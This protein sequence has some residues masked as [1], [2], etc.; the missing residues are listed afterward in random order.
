MAQA[1]FFLFYPPFLA[2]AF[3]NLA[4]IQ[5]QTPSYLQNPAQAKAT[6]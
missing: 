1:T 6:E 4:Q 3:P 5:L 2:T